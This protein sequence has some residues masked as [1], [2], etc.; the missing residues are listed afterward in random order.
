MSTDPSL[1]EVPEADREEQSEDIESTEVL[2]GEDAEPTGSAPAVVEA[3]SADVA[4]QA[5]D[6]GFDDEDHPQS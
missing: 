4:E 1:S 6:V 3:D 5:I 2:T